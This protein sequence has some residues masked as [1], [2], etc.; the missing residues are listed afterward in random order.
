MN[1]CLVTTLKEA[2]DNDNLLKLGNLPIHIRKN[3]NA[4][5]TL[6]FK[7]YGT[8]SLTIKGDG[9]FTNSTGTSNLGKSLVY[10]ANTDTTAYL[11]FG[12]YTVIVP[13]KYQTIQIQAS[14]NGEN[15]AIDLDDCMAM[16]ELTRFDSGMGGAEGDLSNLK[17]SVNILTFSSWNQPLVKGNIADVPKDS[18]FQFIITN[19]PNV[20]GDIGVFGEASNLS[21]LRLNGAT[22]ISGNISGLSGNT[23]LTTLILSNTAVTGDTSSLAGLTNLTTFTYTNTAITGTWPLT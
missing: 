13:D 7:A 15:V 8:N 18:L 22:K 23:A 14:A 20:E 3:K 1:T 16:S 6:S 21:I 2:V 10:Q 5:V 19:N 11:S 12:E 4:V 17:D 9:Y